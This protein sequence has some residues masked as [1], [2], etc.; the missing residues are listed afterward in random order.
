MQSASTLARKTVP[1]RP[2]SSPQVSPTA[3]VLVAAAS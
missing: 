3:V 1:E 2:G